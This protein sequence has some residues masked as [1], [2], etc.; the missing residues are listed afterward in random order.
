MAKPGIAPAAEPPP[1]AT[2]FPDAGPPDRCGG[3]AVAVAPVL[4]RLSRSAEAFLDRLGKA[5]LAA[6]VVSAADSLAS[7]LDAERPALESIQT[8][9]PELDAA[10]ARL[11]TAL[12]ALASAV[13][14]LGAS[15]ADAGRAAARETAS[16]G[17]N[18]AIREWAE[19]VSA[20]QIV[21][22]GVQ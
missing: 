22:P 1:E 3:Y 6:E 9:D 5:R 15:Y 11:A 8:T 4:G 17:L 20:I 2:A 14:E 18:V 19:A 13:R 16:R 7:A 12:S 21:C 10:H